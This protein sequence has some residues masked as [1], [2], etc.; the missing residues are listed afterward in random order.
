V[1]P[2]NDPSGLHQSRMPESQGRPDMPWP[3]QILA[4][5]PRIVQSLPAMSNAKVHAHTRLQ[6][7]LHNA[8]VRWDEIWYIYSDVASKG[9]TL[10][11]CTLCSTATIRRDFPVF[12][13]RHATGRRVVRGPSRYRLSPARTYDA[14]ARHLSSK[15]LAVA[16]HDAQVSHAW[17]VAGYTY[18]Y[19][20]KHTLAL[21]PLQ[22][23]PRRHA[24]SPAR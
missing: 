21:Y 10:Y 16:T 23:H 22:I 4:A 13:Q 1:H 9:G 19:S 8:Q 5:M 11:I 17:V 12:S 14:L 24:A 7:M 3:C 18:I 2:F 15:R 6:H 20:I